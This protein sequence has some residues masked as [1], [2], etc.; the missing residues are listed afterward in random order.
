MRLDGVTGNSLSLTREMDP[1][2][3]AWTSEDP[4]GFGGGEVDLFVLESN[5]TLRFLDPMGTNLWGK[6]G[7]FVAGIGITIIAGGLGGFSGAGVAVLVQPIKKTPP[8]IRVGYGSIVGIASTGFFVMPMAINVGGQQQTFS[9]GFRAVFFRRRTW[10]GAWLI[11]FTAA[12]LADAR[13]VP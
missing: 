4:T 8:N 13:Q 7:G 10:E 3:G 9:G 6:A 5:N 1:S 11:A 2:T 12:W